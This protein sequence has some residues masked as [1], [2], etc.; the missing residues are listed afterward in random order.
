MS[1]QSKHTLHTLEKDITQELYKNAGDYAVAFKDLQTGEE[2]LINA[3]EIFHAASTMKTPVLIEVYKQAAERKFSLSDSLTIQNTFVSI[4]DGSRFSL[5]QKDDSEQELYEYIGK[6]RTISGLCYDMI[7]SSSNLATNMII[8][9]VG[10]SH[11]SNTMRDMGAGHVNVLRG[12]EDSLAFHRGLINTVT[13]RDM[14]VI[15]EQIARG[16]AVSEEASKEMI[17]IL[18]D[19]RFNEIIPAKLPASVRVAHKTG[20]ITGVNHDTGIVM[21]PDG[22]RYVLILLSKNVTDQPA[23]IES[24]SVVSEMIYQYVK[25]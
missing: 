18:L 8:G 3:Q 2:L 11:V 5:N 24:M 22:H 17:S 12:V 21:L 6:K 23:A 7:I 13:A 10:A 15:Y 19:Q 16:K 14:M 1:C 9:L 25:Q 4:V 20:S